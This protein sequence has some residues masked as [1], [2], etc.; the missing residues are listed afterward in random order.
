MRVIMIVARF[1]TVGVRRFAKVGVLRFSKV[2][3]LR[4]EKVDRTRGSVSAA[5]PGR[6]TSERWG[7]GGTEILTR[8]G[9]EIACKNML[10]S[11]KVWSCDG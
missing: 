4:F 1:S 8:R 2:G 9:D 10:R 6:D 11:T 7:L 3:G 5:W